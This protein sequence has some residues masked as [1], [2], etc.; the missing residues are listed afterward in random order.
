VVS[1]MCIRDSL[2]VEYMA[3]LIG[4]SK[5]TLQ[6]KLK[7]HGTT[8]SKEIASLKRDR[9][10]D[11]LVHSSTP[12]CKIAESLG[13]SSQPSFTRAFKSWT[14]QTPREYRKKRGNEI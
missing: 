13:F 12:I 6:R 1:E 10:I 9:A 11:L 8:L 4:Y 5:Q 2:D 14:N 7:S 3:R